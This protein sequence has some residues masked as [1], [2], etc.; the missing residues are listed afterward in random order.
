MFLSKVFTLGFGFPFFAFCSLVAVFC[1]IPTILI[2]LHRCSPCCLNSPAFLPS[3]LAHFKLLVSWSWF[4]QFPTPDSDLL[5]DNLT[6]ISLQ[7]KIG[8]CLSAW[9]KVLCESISF[10]CQTADT[11]WSFMYLATYIFSCFCYKIN[12]FHDWHS[13]SRTNDDS[14]LVREKKKNMASHFQKLLYLA[15]FFPVVSMYVQAENHTH[16]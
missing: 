8:W 15:T 6:W 16:I 12:S 3:E 4:I 5:A 10:P 13:L 9:S 2:H 11:Q 14:D 1:F 7:G